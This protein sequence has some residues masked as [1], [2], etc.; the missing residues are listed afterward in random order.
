[1]A[2]MSRMG[3]VLLKIMKIWY[4]VDIS[5]SIHYEEGMFRVVLLIETCIF[6]R[7][8]G[9]VSLTLDVFVFIDTL[10]YL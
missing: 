5:K 7:N 2:P 10:A 1:M 3:P 8:Y 4:K 9:T 6:W